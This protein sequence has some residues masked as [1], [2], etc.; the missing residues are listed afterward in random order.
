VKKRHV[1]ATLPT[2]GTGWQRALVV[3]GS[4]VLIV[5]AL[6]WASVVIIPLVL[7]I[8]FAFVLN[9]IAQFG[10]RRG[11][12]R[13]VAVLL[14]VLLGV[15]LLTG[16]CAAVLLQVESLAIDLADNKDKIANKIIEIRSYS[17][18]SWLEKVMPPARRTVKSPPSPVAAGRGQEERR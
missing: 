2:N 3:C 4:L 10:Q 12:N 8:L 9:P 14:A 15:T 18:G 1:V 16:L 11:L 5:A 17:H 13:V 7:A 6:Y